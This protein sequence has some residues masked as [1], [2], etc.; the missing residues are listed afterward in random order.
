MKTKLFLL[1]CL[2]LT[3]ALSA[4]GQQSESDDLYFN[5]KD[6]AKEKAARTNAMAVNNDIVAR[7]IKSSDQYSG[8]DVNPE[9]LSRLKT[10]PNTVQGTD[11]PYYDSDYKSDKNY[12]FNNNYYGNSWNNPYNNSWGNSWN[13][14]YYSNMYGY[15]GMNGFGSPYSSFYSPFYSPFASSFYSPFYS[16]LSFGMGMGFGSAWS[17][18]YYGYSPWMNGFYGSP[19]YGY[20]PTTVIVTGGNGESNIVYGKRSSRSSVLDNSTSNNRA[21]VVDRNGNQGQ[22]IAVPAGRTSGTSDRQYYQQNWRN[23]PEVN[24]NN[25]SDNSFNRSQSLGTQ[26]PSWNN[27]NSSRMNSIP[28]N[29]LMSPSRGL[30]SPSRSASPSWGGSGGMSGGGI[31]GGSGHSSSGSRGRN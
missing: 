26:N 12:N 17:S 1:P 25:R 11:N 2:A 30:E 15:P 20:Y 21:T 4:F 8:R 9:Y 6:R 29:G 28:N 16:S 24:T 23:N 22:M 7:G 19:Y 14:P 13:S 3:I 27:G 10:N 31:G 18:P 5:S